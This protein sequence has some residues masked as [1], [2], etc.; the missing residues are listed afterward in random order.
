MSRRWTN[1]TALLLIA[2]GLLIDPGYG[3]PVTADDLGQARGGKS[4]D[5]TISTDATQDTCGECKPLEQSLHSSKCQT[6]SQ[7][8][9]G[10]SAR[11]V[12]SL[13]SFTTSYVRGKSLS[14]TT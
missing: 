10:P 14:T 4:T 3:L 2:A 5:C 7:Q 13:V 1:G 8:I 12:A 11:M 6:I 9:C